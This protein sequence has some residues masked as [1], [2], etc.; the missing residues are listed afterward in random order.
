MRF[1]ALAAV[2]LLVVTLP[3]GAAGLTG[4]YVECRNCDIW[5]GPCFANAEMNL[6]GKHAVLGWKVERG[7]I[8]DVRLDGL[9]VVAVVVADNTLGLDQNGPGK[10][11]LIVDQSANPA[12]R[13]ALVRLAK[14]QAGDLVGDLVAVQAA[15][16]SLDLC[17]CK[18]DA[19]A[20]LNA[21]G[22]KVETRCIDG[23]HD[24]HC[25]NEFAFYPPLA[26]NVKVKA[27]VAV[28]H[29]YSG[30]GLGQTWKETERRGAYVGSFEIK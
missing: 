28:E 23:K 19:C 9:S 20:R 5:T 25:G 29:G 16:I 26:K 22:A 3:A 14:K 10:A 21:G 30:K 24:K 11:L 7:T 2:A 17:P 4:Q 1:L 6:T 18:E 27:A 15:P 12:Q 13:D 8:D